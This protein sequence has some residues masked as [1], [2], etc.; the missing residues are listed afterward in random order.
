[1]AS[2]AESRWICIIY[3]AFGKFK[4]LHFVALTDDV[5]LLWKN[6]LASLYDQRKALMGGLDQMRT[7]QNVWLKQSWSNADLDNDQKLD[8]RDVE[9]LCRNLNISASE[10]DIQANF[11]VSYTAACSPYSV[12]DPKR[13]ISAC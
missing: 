10:S 5:F 2:D 6:T 8:L 12:A 3:T 9:K 11:Q 13:T 1:M 4:I 7:R